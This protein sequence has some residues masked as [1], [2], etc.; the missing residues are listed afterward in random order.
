[1]CKYKRAVTNDCGISSLAIRARWRK[2][3]FVLEGGHLEY[4]DKPQAAGSGKGKQFK[5]QPES[6]TAYTSTENCFC[7]K[8]G[9]GSD[10]DGDCFSVGDGLTCRSCAQPSDEAGEGSCWFLVSK[11]ER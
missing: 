3:W 11:E 1:M 4:F 9:G 7:V 2:R 6:L 10:Y 8:V 5:L